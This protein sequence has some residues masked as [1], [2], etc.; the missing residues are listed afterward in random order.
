M[1]KRILVLCLILFGISG[2]AMAED[3][4]V[5]LD[6]DMGA[7]TLQLFKDKAPVTVDN[8]VQYVNAGFY[9]NTI[10]HRVIKGFMNQGG[11]MG[12]DLKFKEP[13]R[14]AIINESGNGLS[15]LTYTIAMARTTEPNSATS[16]FFINAVDNL[17]LDKKYAQDGVG[18]AVF[19]KVVDGK[20][21]VDAINVVATATVKGNKDMPY[22]PVI[23]TKARV[24]NSPVC[25]NVDD[26]L[27]MAVSCAQY[28]GVQ[29]GF[30]LNHTPVSSDPT[31]HYWKINPTTVYMV[32]RDDCM[33]VGDDLKMNLCA[34]YHGTPFEFVLN[35][36]PIGND[37]AWK[38]DLGTFKQRN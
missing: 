11:G 1:F 34:D 30:I 24:I 10:F 14:A 27:T 33:L 7:I 5:R 28:Q 32:Q 26:T 16:Q 8:F 17:F 35:Y 3:V 6:T 23:I 37:L 20:S 22:P 4:Y 13:S 2:N 31:G 21:V 15:N 19:G 25:F 18:Y 9:D 36:A 38:A 29:Y 12:T